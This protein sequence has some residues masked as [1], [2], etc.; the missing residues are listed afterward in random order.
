VHRSAETRTGQFLVSLGVGAS[1]IEDTVHTPPP[2]CT[3]LSLHN[4][5]SEYPGCSLKNS[6]REAQRCCSIPLFLYPFVAYCMYVVSATHM[7]STFCISASDRPPDHRLVSQSQLGP[8]TWIY[9]SNLAKL[10]L[11]G[12]LSTKIASKNQNKNRHILPTFPP[13]FRSLGQGLTG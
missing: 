7:C 6:R 12:R 10:L 9:Y 2:L 8:S 3:F 4:Y 1:L 5:P 11:G 13:S